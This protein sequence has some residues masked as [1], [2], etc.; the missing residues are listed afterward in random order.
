MT[1]KKAAAGWYADADISDGERYWDGNAWT[2]KRRTKAEQAAE[3]TNRT[4]LLVAAVGIAVAAVSVF[5]PHLETDT[6]QTIV[7]N[8]MI[9]NGLGWGI[10]IV[11]AFAS[12][13]LYRRWT[14]GGRG[15]S[16]LVFGLLTIAYAVFAGTGD[17]VQLEST[18]PL[19][20]SSLRDTASPGIGIYVAGI[21]GL[22][23]AL[24]GAMIAGYLGASSTKPAVV[25]SAASK[26]CP[27]CAEMVLAD[28]N[29]CKHCGHRFAAVAAA[30]TGAAEGP[31]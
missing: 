17:R 7:D 23:M 30:D 4:G 19:A 6:F 27:D 10:L 28:A 5:L 11:G 31:G 9:Q 3:P 15:P 16:I 18:G 12:I 25:T 29:V 26:K 22:I 8:T 20:V 13:G 1:E 2:D 24:G 14:S 21:G